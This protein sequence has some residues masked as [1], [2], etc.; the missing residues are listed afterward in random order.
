[1]QVK[2]LNYTRDEI[3]EMFG[4][5]QIPNDEILGQ[6]YDFRMIPYIFGNKIIHKSINNI[7]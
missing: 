7:K 2:H 6:V 4:L 1:M 5:D 3:I